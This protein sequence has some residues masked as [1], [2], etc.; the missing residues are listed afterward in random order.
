MLSSPGVVGF[1]AVVCG[2]ALGRWL[3]LWSRLVAIDRPQVHRAQ[4][5]APMAQVGSV[6]LAVAEATGLAL[7]VLG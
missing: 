5:L 4:M 1:A 6:A 2:W 3:P 7:G